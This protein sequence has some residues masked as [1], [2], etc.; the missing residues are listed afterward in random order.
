MH[1]DGMYTSE[2]ASDQVA[3][4]LVLLAAHEVRATKR[5]TQPKVLGSFAH[6]NLMSS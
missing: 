2:R 4:Q 6:S 5:H 1:A 3:M